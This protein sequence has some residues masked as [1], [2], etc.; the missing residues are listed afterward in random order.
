MTT[1]DNAK[2][3][4][5]FQECEAILARESP[6]DSPSTSTSATSWSGPEV[7]GWYDNLLDIHPLNGVYLAPN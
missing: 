2:R 3:Y 7:K 4:E 6:A 5:Y 1:A